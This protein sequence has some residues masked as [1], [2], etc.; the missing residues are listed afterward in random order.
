MKTVVIATGL[1][2]FKW[3]LDRFMEERSVMAIRHGCPK[4][5]GEQSADIGSCQ[6]LLSVAVP[7]ASQ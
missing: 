2:V 5:T 6:W 3:R 4:D 1:D 7:L